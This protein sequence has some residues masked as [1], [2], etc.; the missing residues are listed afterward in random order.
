M[1]LKKKTAVSPFVG[2]PNMKS[3]RTQKPV[4]SD[5]QYGNAVKTG[6]FQEAYSLIL[7]QLWKYGYL[8]AHLLRYSLPHEY[9]PE[10]IKKSLKWLLEN[11]FIV[12]YEFIHMEGDKEFGSSKVYALS[13][14][15]FSLVEKTGRSSFYR[16]NPQKL[17]KYFSIY[18]T[19]CVLAAN[20]FE[21]FFSNQFKGIYASEYY[22]EAWGKAGIPG[23]YKIKVNNKNMMIY[24]IAIRRMDG[25]GKRYLDTL[26]RLRMIQE[27][28]G[29][30]YGVVMCICDVDILANEAKKMKCCEKELRDIP[31]YYV[32]DVTL[33][34]G[35]VFGRLIDVPAE[36]DY[37]ER[38]YFSLLVDSCLDCEEESEN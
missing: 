15:G 8:N 30:P 33:V 12:Q 3:R 26:R 23:A 22:G 25:W 9:A 38:R 27:E 31:V 19:L 11:G 7:A 36:K 34:S 18:D 5:K 14:G 13:G 37:Q 17:E 16:T 21:I 6:E 10:Y 2:H 1:E 28:G 29:L 20:Q 4:M 24:I 32:N 35:D